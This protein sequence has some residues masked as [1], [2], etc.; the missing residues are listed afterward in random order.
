VG[1]TQTEEILAGL[2]AAQREAVE[3]V[4][5]PV[6]VLAGPGSGKTRVLT[7]R[8]AY[9]VRE[10]QVPARQIMAVTFTNKAAREMKERLFQLLG[11]QFRQ[12]TI[13]TFHAI[14]ARV[15]RQEAEAAGI[16]PQY[17]IYDSADQLSLVRQAIRALNLDD[18]LYRPQSMHARI[19]QA[20]NE[21]QDP[22][23]M[24][25]GTYREEVARRVYERYQALLAENGALDFDDLLM[26][27]VLLLRQDDEVRAKYQRRYPFILVDEWQDT[28][29]A[30]YELV[31]LLA[32]ARANLFVVGDEDQ[33]VVAGT[34]I[35]TTAG[36]RPVESLRAGD[37]IVAAAG[38][39]STAHTRIDACSSRPYTGRVLAITTVRGYRLVATPEHC[40][41]ARFPAGGRY[42][43]VYLMYSRRMGYRIG[44]TGSIRTNGVKAYPGFTE[45]LRQ[46]RGDAIWLLRACQDSGEAAYWEAL[47]AARYG[48]PTACFYA[49]GRQ[50][51]M[52]EEHIAELYAQID[53]ESAA[54]RL[55]SD[56]GLD[57]GQPHHVP[58]AT[59]R[60][61][62]VRKTIS[63]VMF[64]SEST[65]S[66]GNRWHRNHDPWHRHEL[67]I[68]SSDP[69][70]REQV[71]SVLQTKPHK[72]L[73]WSARRS[74]GDY[75]AL[76]GLLGSLSSAIPDARVWKRAKLGKSAYDFLPIGHVL[77]GALVPVLE[78]GEI[79]EDE[80]ATVTAELYSGDVYDL[81]VPVCR[82]YV[83]GGLVVHNSIY[84]FRG[85]D[86]RNVARFREDFP[87]ARI[88]LLER[89]YRSTQTILDVANAVIARNV[90]RH[91][92]KLFTEK[93]GGPQ[94]SVVEAYDQQEE[95]DW[96]VGE[97]LRLVRQG[98]AK[99][100]DCAVMYRTNAQSRPLEDAFV[101]RSL[102]YKLVGATRFYE[103]KEI[104]DVLAYL[105]LIHNPYDGVG[106]TRIINVP[107]RNIG[108]Q[109]VT[110]LVSWAA[111][112]G[113]PVYAALQMLAEEGGEAG[114]RTDGS[115]RP[116][117]GAPLGARAKQ[118][119]VSFT[120]LLEGLIR[121][122]REL[123][124]LELLDLLLEQTQYGAFVCD[125]TEE[126]Q[127]RWENILE[128][129]SVARDYADLPVETALSTFLEE[130]ALV[131]DVD[132]LDEKVDAP[133]LLTLHAAKG[134]E[135]R[136][137]FIAGMEEKL[138]PHSRSMDDPE[139]MEEERRLCY[140]GVTRAKD[141]LYLLHT[142]RRT[143]YGESEVR[144]P[145]RYLHDVP[146]HLVTGRRVMQPARQPSLGLEP[147]RFL[148]RT[149]AGTF[150]SRPSEAGS[151][152]RSETFA[153]QED[154]FAHPEDGEQTPRWQE[155]ETATPRR[156]REQEPEATR[157]QAGDRVIHKV[158][159]DGIVTASKPVSG[160]EEVTVAFPGV[161][162]KRLMASLAPMEKAD[163]DREK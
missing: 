22:A 109:T 153:H 132:T 120:R 162:L 2:N 32:G 44:R 24:P 10:C 46:E 15:L 3:A 21:L 118:A 88:I 154:T 151:R 97:I 133:T 63:F 55:A 67:S 134:L 20:K 116:G 34:C 19:S 73:Y 150:P 87:G 136:V 117:E 152:A 143:L 84:R 141:R 53:T 128:L 77:P 54:H 140:V 41:F 45:R 27:A 112:M 111:Q 38:H 30:Q 122:R 113:V 106:L 33:C 159:G 158:F 61:G 51:A 93:Q 14:C 17:V 4:E 144:E 135:Y 49:V 125:G 157:F 35:E 119:L 147:G 66:G 60:G 56:L 47:Y 75:D 13:G 98:D 79:M 102:P 12:L 160:D 121:A 145:S 23:A 107:P 18:K 86:Y 1:V 70:F 83:A 148:G 26:K 129:R 105:R 43:H 80:V 31:R 64:G 50:L 114:A 103:R 123:N 52:T 104:K 7:Y 94:I 149:P 76:D 96:I 91:P 16:S 72:R 11:E 92:K 156:G 37:E 68:C 131:S 65:K 62:K 6:L 40:V 146:E 127:A 58:Q 90:H 85:A 48:L 9:L 8:V 71:E 138:L 89:N 139:Q 108:Q 28:N 81:S 137:V 163:K 69:V 36:P 124:L 74:H 110:T 29:I 82:N 101:R 5:G 25:A 42:Q 59:I 161:G 99:L 115:P 100:G 95:G 126:G 155:R 130:V 57:L 39:G 142:F 78:A